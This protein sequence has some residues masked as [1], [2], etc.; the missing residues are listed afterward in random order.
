[1][2]NQRRKRKD[3]F[4]PPSIPYKEQ[5]RLLEIAMGCKIFINDRGDME[6]VSNCNVER[7]L[8]LR[9]QARSTGRVQRR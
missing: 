9:E 4:I 8:R 1:M 7:R 6:L 2:K 5:M 3:G